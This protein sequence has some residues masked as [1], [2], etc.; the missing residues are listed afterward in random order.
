MLLERKVVHDIPLHPDLASQFRE[1]FCLLQMKLQELWKQLSMLLRD[2]KVSPSISPYEAFVLFAKKK[3]GGLHMYIDY[4][5][6]NFQTIKNQ[7][8]L[9]CI[10]DLLNQLYEAKWFDKIDLT[11]SY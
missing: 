2:E 9:P 3:D 8:T 6:L 5:A 10:N 4:W 1:I 7:Y 11:S